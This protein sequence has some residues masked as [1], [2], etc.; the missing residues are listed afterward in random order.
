MNLKDMTDDQLWQALHDNEDE[1][2][3]LKMEIVARMPERRKDLFR[4]V[5][6]ETR[7]ALNTPSM[8]ERNF[9]G[10]V[11]E[12]DLRRTKDGNGGQD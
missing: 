2:V 1:N 3:R 4:V 9:I 6:E 8:M 12:G 7:K 10:Y 11:S 5:K